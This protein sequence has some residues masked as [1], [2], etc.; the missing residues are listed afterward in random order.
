MLPAATQGFEC[1]IHI[2][3]FNDIK[4][5]DVIEAAEA[6]REQGGIVCE[7]VVLLDR[8]QGGQE[9]IRAHNIE[10]HVLFSI[11]EAFAWLNEVN[12]LSDKDHRM[13]MQYI[14]NERNGITD[15]EKDSRNQTG[16][17]GA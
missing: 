7:L 6:A 16:K 12:L 2:T 17:T 11:S 8:E 10:P 3:N 15:S 13:I 5:G 4:V 1:G 9:H 14:Q